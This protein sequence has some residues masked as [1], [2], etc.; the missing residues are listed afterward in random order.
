MEKVMIGKQLCL[1][2]PAVIAGALVDGRENYLT[3]GGCGGLSLTPPL[4]Y[5]TLNKSHYTNSGIKENGYFSVNLPSTDMTVKTDYVGLVSGRDTD[6]SAVFTS[7]YGDIKKAPM[8][9]ECTVNLLC[10]I[11]KTIDLPH[12]EVFIGEVE[13]TY[14]NAD[15]LD[16]KVPDMKKINPM[17][18]AA[19]KYWGLG[20]I[21]GVAFKDGRALIKN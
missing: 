3:L 10:K 15:C 9:E 12:N 1:T 20:D 2:S 8:I 19:G 21:V 13:E 11:Y 5:I 16:G 17:I 6:K 7:F 4:L 18:L 14:V